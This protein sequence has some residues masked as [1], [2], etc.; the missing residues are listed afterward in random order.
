M[1]KTPMQVTWLYLALLAYFG[2][3][4]WVADGMGWVR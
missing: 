2:V 4:Y 1:S 3:F